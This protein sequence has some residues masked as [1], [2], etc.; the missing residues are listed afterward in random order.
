MVERTWLS[1][2]IL[3]FL[4]VG[5]LSDEAV[6]H[7]GPGS[8]QDPRAKVSMVSVSGDHGG[9]IR[10]TVESRREPLDSLNWS[11][12]MDTRIDGKGATAFL[13]GS[14]EAQQS[15]VPINATLSGSNGLPAGP[16]TAYT[17]AYRT[18]DSH[19]HYLR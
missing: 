13:Y 17:F 15:G 11:L 10:F 9:S 5:C 8:C 3:A 16:W 14:W 2:L 6:E 4:L 18:R 12:D 19:V 1:G 7:L